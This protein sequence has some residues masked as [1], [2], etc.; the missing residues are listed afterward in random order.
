MVRRL[1][2]HGRLAQLEETSPALLP[3]YQRRLLAF[4]EDLEALR[5]RS[6]LYISL[7]K[8]SEAISDL[9]S[10]IAKDARDEWSL[11]LRANSHRLTGS[12]EAAVA[13]FDRALSRSRECVELS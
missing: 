4:P 9:D 3:Y 8:H 6:K 5:E 10:I 1:N 2:P 7:D 11:A 12:P 13:E